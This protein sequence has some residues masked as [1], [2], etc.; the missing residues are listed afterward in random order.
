MTLEHQPEQTF[1]PAIENAV[2]Y[3]QW[4]LSQFG[5]AIGSNIVEVGIGHG[6]YSRYMPSGAT[7][8]GVDID[9]ANVERARLRH[10]DSKFVEGDIT[11]D[12]F[13]QAFQQVAPDT[14]IC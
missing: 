7:Y 6:G 12:A 4:V 13:V 2:N 1:A 5:D 11:A 10:P 3:T 14:I 9:P 8:C